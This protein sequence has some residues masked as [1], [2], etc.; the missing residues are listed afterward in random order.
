MYWEDELEWYD[1][2]DDSDEEILGRIWNLN[3]EEEEDGDYYN[4]DEEEHA[5]KEREYMGSYK[6]FITSINI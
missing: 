6:T 4:W 3:N 5:R 2:D 1:Y